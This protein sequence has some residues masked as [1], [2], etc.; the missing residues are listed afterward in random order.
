MI[1]PT[2]KIG[3]DGGNAGEGGEL[4]TA[5]IKEQRGAASG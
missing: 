2:E 3:M 5:Q 4:K 1:E